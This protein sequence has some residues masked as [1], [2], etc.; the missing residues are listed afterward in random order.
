M[1]LQMEL[2][3]GQGG[4]HTHGKAFS[5]TGQCNERWRA[6]S[7]NATQLLSLHLVLVRER[8]LPGNISH[9]APS[10][11]PSLSIV[12]ALGAHVLCSP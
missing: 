1:D 4:L 5:T 9:W 10:H 6:R 12:S 7:C 3:G 11:I 8:R 2:A